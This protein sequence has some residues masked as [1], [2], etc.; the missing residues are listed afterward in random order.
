M[1]DIMDYT[2]DEKLPGILVSLDFTKEFD[3]LEWS[4]VKNWVLELY[5]FGEGVERW[6]GIFLQYRNGSIK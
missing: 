1:S 5:N 3:T 6:I 2:K 4:F